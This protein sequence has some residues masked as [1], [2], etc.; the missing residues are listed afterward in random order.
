MKQIVEQFP[1]M[2]KNPI[3]VRQARKDDAPLEPLPPK[4]KKSHR[5]YENERM[6]AH[7]NRTVKIRIWR[8]IRQIGQLIQESMRQKGKDSRQTQSQ[9]GMPRPFK[10]LLDDDTRED[11]RRLLHKKMHFNVALDKRESFSLA[12]P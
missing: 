7:P 2:I 8:V 11:M 4:Y 1:A 3:H 6:I 9:F 10:R 12:A 5:R